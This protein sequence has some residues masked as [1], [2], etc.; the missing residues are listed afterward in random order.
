MSGLYEKEHGRGTMECI[1][2][3]GR[4][5]I[6]FGFPKKGRGHKCKECGGSGLVRIDNEITKGLND[7]VL[8]LK[9]KIKELEIDLREK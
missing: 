8:R 7:E 5:K 2:C 6:Y 1:Y 3:N 9:S 4:G